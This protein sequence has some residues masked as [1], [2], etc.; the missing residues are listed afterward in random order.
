VI[1][2]GEA[3]L[4]AGVT[5]YTPYNLG[6]VCGTYSS[7][8]STI[9][10]GAEE[11][12]NAPVLLNDFLSPCTTTI[13][14]VAGVTLRSGNIIQLFPGF[15]ASSGCLFTAL[16]D[17]CEMSDY[18]ANDLRIEDDANH[19]NISST[20]ES[21]ISI[22]PNPANDI[23]TIEFEVNEEIPVSISIL[24]VEGRIRQYLFNEKLLTGDHYKTQLSTKDFSPGLYVCVMKTGENVV[25]KKFLVQH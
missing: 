13:T 19:G 1:S 20:D 16:I 5:H 2:V 14:T 11:I 3:W 25:T 24:D 4:A 21:L 12:R 6:S 9:I 23:A 18:D 7:I 17:E 10:D 8:F 15:T 22:Y